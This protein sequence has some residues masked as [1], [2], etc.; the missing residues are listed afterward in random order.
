MQGHSKKPSGD[1]GD[2]LCAILAEV[3]S[4]LGHGHAAGADKMQHEIADCCERAGSRADAASILV[5]CHITHIVKPV[6]DG[7][8]AARQFK[9]AFGI[10]FGR[11]QAGDNVGGLS[12]DFSSDLPGAFDAGDL[13][14]A[15]PVKVS[16]DLG[17]DGDFADLDAAVFLVN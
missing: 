16:N 15:G 9:Q 10:S 13:G 4:G 14:G 7:P 1:D 5:E 17:A 8:V 6:L 3:L 11:G 12:G 2:G